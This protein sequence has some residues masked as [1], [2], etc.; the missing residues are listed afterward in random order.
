[1]QI[2]SVSF[3]HRAKRLCFSCFEIFLGFFCYICNVAKNEPTVFFFKKKKKK[4]VKHSELLII[5][6]WRNLTV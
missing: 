2:K 3:T 5:H 1:M 4:D 6:Q